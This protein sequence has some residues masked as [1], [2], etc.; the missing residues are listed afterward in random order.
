MQELFC[1][2]IIWEVSSVLSGRISCFWFLKVSHV[3]VR[4]KKNPF[5]CAEPLSGNGLVFSVFVYH[6]HLSVWAL[7]LF[8]W[9][10][11]LYIRMLIMQTFFFLMINV[12]IVHWVTW[13][14]VKGTSSFSFKAI[15]IVYKL[16]IDTKM[17]MWLF[18]YFSLLSC[19]F[20]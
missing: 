17:E 19:W 10:R 14:C 13:K 6:S 3:P 9:Q 20:L 8:L 4:K 18:S 2:I 5:V 12:N 1:H 11:H 15:V 16:N 7:Y